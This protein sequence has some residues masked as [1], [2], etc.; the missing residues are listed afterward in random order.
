MIVYMCVHTIYSFII[1]ISLF[2]VYVSIIITSASSR[3]VGG[4]LINE[5]HL[6]FYLVMCM[7]VV[8]HHQVAGIQ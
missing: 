5:Q 7:G 2:Y 6:I 8:R 1:Q 4:G 3:N